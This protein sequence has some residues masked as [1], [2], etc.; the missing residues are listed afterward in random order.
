M[1]KNS[2]EIQITGLVPETEYE[3]I[4]APTF[5]IYKDGKIYLRRVFK[6][7]GEIQITGLV[8]ETEYEIIGK[9]IYLNAEN[10]KVENTFYKGTIKTKGY[11]ALGV[12]EL[13]KENGEIYNNKIQIKEKY[14][15]IRYE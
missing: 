6:N 3:I 4:G 10:K 8:P 7:S 14:I 2:G 13:S 5:E 9:Y 1:F 12:I 11:E 15:V